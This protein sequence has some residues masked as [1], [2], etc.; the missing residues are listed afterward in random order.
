MRN[1]ATES[2]KSKGQF[3]TPSEVSRILAKV[4][5]IEKAKGSDTTLY[6]PACGSASLLIRAA[7][8][9][10]GS[11]SVYGQEKEITTAGLAR[12]N[13][14]LHNLATAEIKGGYSTFSDPQYPKEGDDSILRQFDF[15]VA[16]PPFST[17]NWTHGLKEYGRFD[18]YGDRPPQ[19]NGDFA[20]MLHII[21]SL[22]RKGKAAVILPHGVLFRGNAEGTIR[23]SLIDK[24]LIKG[25]IG[26]PANLFYGTGIPA[27]IIVIDKENADERDGIFMIDASR[28]F[29]KDGDKTRLRERD[30][31]KITNVFNQRLE[32]P[33]YS[34]FVPNSEIKNKNAYNLNIP[35]YI[36]SGAPEDLQNIEGH[37][38]GGIPKTDVDGSL[39]L[40]WN[41]FSNLKRKLFKPLAERKNFYSLAMKQDDI[42]DTICNDP[43]FS[44]YANKVETAFESWKALVDR[45]LRTINNKTKPKLLIAEM[46]V[47]ILKKFESVTLVDKY[48]AYEVLLSYWNETMS[49]D[50]YL[51]VQDG[52]RAIREIEVFSTTTKKKK[53]DGTEVTKTTE[54]G[55]DGKLVPKNLV[56]E[57]FFPADQKAINDTEAIIAAA[58]A[59]LDEM[60]ETAEEDSVI[61][62]VL[63]E[64]TGNLDKAEL[65]KKLKD[66]TL[67]TDDKNILQKLSGLIVLIDEGSKVLKDLRVVLDKKV[68]A[69]YVKLTDRQAME[70]LLNCKWYRSLVHGMFALYTAVTHRITECVSELAERYEHTMPSLEKNVAELENK[71]KAHLKKMGFVW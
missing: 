30:V 39:S 55:W 2:G 1:F 35:R 66:A 16:N 27:C 41:T 31:Y 49:D 14:V 42:R 21:K 11:I 24:G 53:K 70:L 50:I 18:G 58:Q 3:Y 71:V 47:Q 59:E 6:D 25:I 4:V 19:K 8:A 5:G 23:K 69:Q 60:I 29:V 40:Y 12:M 44:A 46:A 51:L 38:K 65:K 64:D 20:W 62:D 36:D 63:K 15:I 52:Y 54:T 26:L 48:D 28:D 37:L 61:G 57:M 10:P 56:I 67:D 13:L 43:E 68:R 32:L 45:K 33:K 17:K 7:E 9:A 22:K 34:R